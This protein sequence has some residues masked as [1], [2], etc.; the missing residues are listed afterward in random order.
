MRWSRISTRNVCP[1]E[2]TSAT[3]GNGGAS[4]ASSPGS[5][6]PARVDVALEV[7][8][9]D[10]RLVVRPRERLREVDADEQRAREPG[11]ARHRDPVDVGDRRAGGRERLVERGHD[12]AQVG[13]RGDLGDDA[14]RRRVER[15]LARDDVRVDPGAVLDDRHA[16]LV[17]RGSRSRA[18]GVRSRDA[19]LGSRP[20][21][22]WRA[23]RAS[24]SSGRRTA[25]ARR[26]AP[27]AGGR[28]ARASTGRPAAPW[29]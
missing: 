27:P 16:R 14:A 17:A 23:P 26:R 8:H 22:C 12:P 1:P 5:S 3:S 20:G 18:G 7:V 10:E 9:A 11:A 24:A 25:A 19:W 15:D 28:C 2:T 29:S 13:P 6:E 4:R 21:A